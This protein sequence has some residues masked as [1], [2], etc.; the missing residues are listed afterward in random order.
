MLNITIKQLED[1][2]ISLA[3]E[4]P[5]FSEKTISIFMLDEFESRL[6]NG[7][8]PP[9]VAVGY[10]GCEPIQE[11]QGTRTDGKSGR[12]GA[13]M[14]NAQFIIVIAT[15]YQYTGQGDGKADG[16]ALL[17]QLRSKIFGYSGVNSRPWRFMGERPEPEDSS[18]GTIFYSQ[19]WQTTLSLTT[20]TN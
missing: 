1:E 10:D 20:Q 7:F 4:I 15:Q 6:A 9:V 18:D 2:L 8:V 14:L 5:I 3:K 12:C 11:N 16:F 13:I 19:V 17:D